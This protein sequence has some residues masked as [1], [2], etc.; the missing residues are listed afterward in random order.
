MASIFAGN[1]ATEFVDDA[2]GFAFAASGG[3]EVDVI[4]AVCFVGDDEGFVGIAGFEKFD[5]IE[6]HGF[7]LLGINK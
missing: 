2:D 7:S 6:V 3:G 4:A 5:G 1:G